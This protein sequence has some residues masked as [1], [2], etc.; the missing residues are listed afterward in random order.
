[1]IISDPKL[2]DIVIW[3]LVV[4]PHVRGNGFAKVLL[5]AIMT[6]YPMKTWHVP[7]IL[8]EEL[9]HVF[10]RVGFVREHLSQWQMKLDLQLVNP[11]P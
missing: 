11:H 10:E 7:A 1:M 5:K 8:P 4:E 6:Q 3:A 2:N 9:G